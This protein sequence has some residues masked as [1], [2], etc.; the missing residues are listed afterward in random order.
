MGGFAGGKSSRLEQK[1]IDTDKT[2]NVSSWDID[3][4]LGVFAHH[5]NS[6]LHSL[7]EQVVLLAGSVVRTLDADLETRL[8]GT[9]EDTPESIETTTVRSRYHLGNVQ[10]ERTLGI[11][12]PDTNGRLVIMGT[13]VQGLHT[14]S[15]SGLGRWQMQNHH[16]QE[17]ISSWQ[18]FPHDNLKQ[19]LALEIL[20]VVGEL[21][22]ELLAKLGDL[23]LLE[24]ADG[25]EDAENRVQ[26]ELVEGTLDAIRGS[27]GPLL[28]LWVEVVVT[29]N[30]ELARR[31]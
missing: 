23:V 11:A 15:L 3:D 8:D 29:L 31:N 14:V 19:G 26:N 10:H 4:W 28:G 27:L 17:S 21:D 5:E 30:F 1:L 24:V 2:A 13:L 9:G 18:E 6:T 20:L 16:F 22:L 25:L 12:V 7:D